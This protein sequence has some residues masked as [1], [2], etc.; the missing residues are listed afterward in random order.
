MYYPDKDSDMFEYNE[1]DFLYKC[2]REELNGTDND[3]LNTFSEIINFVDL[4]I[5]DTRKYAYKKYPFLK[6]G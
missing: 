3:K 5:K 2:T 4:Q 1:N 6:N